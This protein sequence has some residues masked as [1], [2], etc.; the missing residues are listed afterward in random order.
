MTEEKIKESFER[1]N[2]RYLTDEKESKEKEENDNDI[3]KQQN[4]EEAAN[5]D[6]EEDLEDL[7]NDILIFKNQTKLNV[8][9]Y[10]TNCTE[11]NKGLFL[12]VN[13]NE[14]NMF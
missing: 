6:F 4:N 3:I 14:K 12:D 13:I 8:R 9:D 11:N 7:Q 10:T 5:E 1:I 2:I